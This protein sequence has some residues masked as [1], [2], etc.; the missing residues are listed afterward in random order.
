M[1]ITIYTLLFFYLTGCSSI[2]ELVNGPNDDSANR[3]VIGCYPNTSPGSGSTEITAADWDDNLNYS[4]FKNYLRKS[5][6]HNLVELALPSQS[7]QKVSASPLL[8]E[9][10]ISFVIDTTGSMGDELS[11]LTS[12]LQSIIETIKKMNQSRKTQFS[13]IL[14]RDLNDEYQTKRLNFTDSTESLKNFINQQ[15]ASGGGDYEEAVQVA[16][17]EALQ[18]S[19]SPYPGTHK[20]LFHLADAPP[21][22]LDIPTVISQIQQFRQNDI[23]I[24]PIAASGVSEKAETLMRYSAQQTGGRYIFLTDDSGIGTP[25]KV[26]SIPC[27]IVRTFK[28]VLTRIVE[29]HLAGMYLPPRGEETV[30]IEGSLSDGKCFLGDDQ[31]IGRLW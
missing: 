9:L 11:Y 29:G 8:P 19:W 14:Y 25:H 28:T 12:E 7:T 21:H 17:Y 4:L 15:Q 6:L 27:Y 13:I 30:R 26:P 23:T 3:E 24:Y 10:Q 22:D 5:P 31:I 18:Q 2:D 16:F 20:V 1:K